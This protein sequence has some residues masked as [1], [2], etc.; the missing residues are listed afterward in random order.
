M[1]H[2]LHVYISS[3]MSWWKE[4]QWGGKLMHVQWHKLLWY[5]KPN[6]NSRCQLIFYHNTYHWMSCFAAENDLTAKVW[7]KA[8]DFYLMQ[9]VTEYL[10]PLQQNFS[11]TLVSQPYYSIPIPFPAISINIF[12]YEAATR[13]FLY[14]TYDFTYTIF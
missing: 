7:S 3:I 12:L 5:N 14:T 6:W 9:F 8:H 1:Y 13:I 10:L 4:H 11:L 2:C